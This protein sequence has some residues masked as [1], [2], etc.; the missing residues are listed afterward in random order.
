MKQLIK[1]CMMLCAFHCMLHAQIVRTWDISFGKEMKGPESAPYSLSIHNGALHIGGNFSRLNGNTQRVFNPGHIS[2]FSQDFW[3]DMQGGLSGP[4]R[5]MHSANDGRL[6]VAGGF[7]IQGNIISQGLAYW[8]NGTWT[9]IPGLR[10]GSINSLTHDGTSLFVGGIFPGMDD[11]ESPAIARFSQGKW[12]SM[13]SGLRK[14]PTQSKT[15]AE[16]KVLKY[17][18]GR[19]YVGGDFDSAGTISTKNIAYWDGKDWHALGAGIPGIINDMVILNNGNIIV[20]STIQSGMIREC[21]PLMSW[22]GNEW[23]ILGLP[24]DCSSIQALATDG[25]NVFVGGEFTMDSSRNNYGLALWDGTSFTSIGGGV[26]GKISSL[27]YHESKLYCG[28]TFLSVSDSLA[29][30]NIAAFQIH[31][32]EKT[33]EDS[34]LRIKTFPNPNQTGM[35]SISFMIEEP[36]EAE[37]CLIASDGRIVQCFAKG[38]YD[39]GVHEVFLNIAGLSSGQYQCSLYYQGTILSTT[40]HIMH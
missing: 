39:A 28:G 32:K 26:K 35:V 15:Q 20:A 2:Y 29:C 30:R 1:T 18:Q 40:M 27:L 17:A 4:I 16:V 14:I 33:D 8:E 38:Y 36:G 22:N 25:K 34:I 19:L 24:P 11:V 6:Y 37:L 10:F 7:M 31:D 5:S 12:H 13:Q 3:Q 23:S 21:A 9:G